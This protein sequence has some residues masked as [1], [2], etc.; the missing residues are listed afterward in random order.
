MAHRI[1]WGLIRK[2]DGKTTTLRN[3]TW[4][5]TMKPSLSS[6]LSRERPTTVSPYNLTTTE[7]LHCG[8]SLNL[9]TCMRSHPPSL[10]FLFLRFLSSTR[11]HFSTRR[12][13]P[14]LIPDFFFCSII[15]QQNFASHSRNFFSLC[16]VS[17]RAQYFDTRWWIAPA[18]TTSL[19]EHAGLSVQVSSF[20]IQIRS[21]LLGIG[22]HM[23]WGSH[24]IYT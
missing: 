14:T 22:G 3:K 4:M 11:P 15:K 17:S 24:N 21:G 16:Q 5:V 12:K 1:R 23:L 7:Q 13:L 9:A 8:R 2:L 19:K 20:G 10:P 6:Y 18:K